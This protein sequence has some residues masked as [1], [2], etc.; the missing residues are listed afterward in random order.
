LT[1]TMED[2]RLPQAGKK[3]MAGDTWK[4]G[5]WWG[6]LHLGSAFCRENPV[7]IDSSKTIS[8][9]F[10]WIALQPALPPSSG[11]VTIPAHTKV[12]AM[13]VA[14]DFN[15]I[16]WDMTGFT[17]SEFPGGGLPALLHD[18]WRY[19][20]RLA[21]GYQVE[22]GGGPETIYSPSPVGHYVPYWKQ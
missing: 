22:Y 8:Q 12:T 6:W 17:Y 14:N 15:P 21:Y 18:Y 11:W 1:G 13:V 5:A 2:I 7:P 20:G 4:C 16:V 10:G 9:S 3:W 19:D